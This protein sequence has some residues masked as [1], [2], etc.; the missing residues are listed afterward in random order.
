MRVDV[1]RENDTHMIIDPK[2]HISEFQQLRALA[3]FFFPPKI[4]VHIILPDFWGKIAFWNPCVYPDS[5]TTA[6]D[7]FG[8]FWFSDE[9]RLS[10]FFDVP[11]KIILIQVGVEIYPH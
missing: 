8:D 10:R 1:S 11:D 9:S 5:P 3:I 4:K 7:F 2:F 6:L